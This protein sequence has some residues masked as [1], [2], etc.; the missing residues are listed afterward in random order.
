MLLV[1]TG[2]EALGSC[3][4][5]GASFELYGKQVSNDSHVQVVGCV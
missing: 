3:S 1:C 4:A 5:R 2:K